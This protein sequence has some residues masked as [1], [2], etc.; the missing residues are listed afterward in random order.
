MVEGEESSDAEERGW[1]CEERKVGSDPRNALT[2]RDL[3]GDTS[4]SLVDKEAIC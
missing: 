4:K 3:L 2:Q 1:P